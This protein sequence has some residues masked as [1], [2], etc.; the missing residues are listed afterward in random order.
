MVLRALACCRGQRTPATRAQRRALWEALGVIVDDLAS[1]VLVL[2]I[3]GSGSPLG[4]WLTEAAVL[5]T[6]FRITLHQLTT[7]PITLN[8]SRLWVCENPAVLRAAAAELGPRCASVACTE[9]IPS[10]A[11][12]HLVSHAPVLYWRSDFGWTG[13]RV[14]GGAIAPLGAAPWRRSGA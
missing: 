9:G 4:G 8:I 2:N 12:H 5:G 7:M 11:F 10:A 14:T 3:P 6:P 13:L 1:Q